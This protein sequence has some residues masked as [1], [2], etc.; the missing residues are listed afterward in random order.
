M[1]ERKMVQRTVDLQTNYWQLYPRR[2]DVFLQAMDRL[3]DGFGVQLTVRSG[4]KGF[5]H[6][7]YSVN[8][9]PVRKAED[10]RIPIRF[11][12]LHKPD[13]QQTKTI[14][15]SVSTTG[16]ESRPYAIAINFYPKEMYAASGQNAPG[17]II[18]QQTDL[19]LTA[20][21]VED[22][23]SQ[24]PSPADVEFARKTWGRAISATR[25]DY[26]NARALARAIM[27][28]LEPHQGIPSD[29]M[30]AISP[31]DQ[32]RRAMA[33]TDHV[34]CGNIAVIFTC[35]S[36]ALGIPCRTIGMNRTGP[37]NPA[38]PTLLLAEGHG[39]TEIFSESL[40]AWVWMDLTFGILG[41]YQRDEGPLTMAELYA[42]LNDP[43][44]VKGL[45]IV[46]YDPKAKADK[47]QSAMDS[48]KKDSLF[49]YFKRDQQFR[50]TR[51]QAE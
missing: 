15:K 45:R 11:E 33:G 10:G 24:K 42:N 27:D 19:A 40:N 46:V 21:S 9:G 51:W 18:I 16:A 32:Y 3:P 7:A 5:S 2:E 49:N 6:F 22:W 4:M 20:G 48:D 37:A 28:D 36:N 12:D 44:R 30:G 34:W 50:Y 26:E 31:F 8:G 1:P 23:I 47:T 25:P 41:A 13:I 29:Q 38:G 35:A 17:Y 39:T 14:V 43:N